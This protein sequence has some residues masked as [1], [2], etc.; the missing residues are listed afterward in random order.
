MKKIK[1][2]ILKFMVNNDTRNMSTNEFIFKYY[3]T[4]TGDSTLNEIQF[5]QL[6]S[7]EWVTRARRHIIKIYWIWERTKADTQE[8][9]IEEYAL[10]N[11]YKM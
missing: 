5:T 6:P 10:Q 7:T 2:N 11:K 4:L 3:Q 9:Y 1:D 8:V